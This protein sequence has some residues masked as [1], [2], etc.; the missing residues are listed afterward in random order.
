MSEKRDKTSQDFEKRKTTSSV[1][2]KIGVSLILLSGVFFFSM[3]AVPWLP[4]GGA[5]KVVLAGVLFVGVQVAW[6]VGAALVGPATIGAMRSWF[7]RR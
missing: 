7:R 6:W 1:L 5:F 2:G 3:F 4:I